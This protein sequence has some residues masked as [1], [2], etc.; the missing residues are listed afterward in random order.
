MERVE[1]TVTDI[2]VRLLLPD[3]SSTDVP[4]DVL[5]RSSVLLDNL[6]DAK[7]G[8]RFPITMPQ[9][10]MSSW[11]QHVACPTSDSAGACHLSKLEIPEQQ[12]IMQSL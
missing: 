4:Q 10:L 1:V 11:L 8:D 9:G 5:S 12:H 7:S 2:G 3:R 6:D